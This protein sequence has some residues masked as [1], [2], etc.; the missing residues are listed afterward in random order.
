[1]RAGRVLRSLG[2]GCK[3][4]IDDPPDFGAAGAAIGSGIQFL[5]DSLNA[6]TATPDGSDDL[7]CADAEA[8][9]DGGSRIHPPSARASGNNGEPLGHVGMS[10]SQLLDRPVAGDCD[11]L[12]G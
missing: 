6:V 11:R 8:G 5:A 12:A 3:A 7:V 2:S 10:D 1:M 4:S 9:T